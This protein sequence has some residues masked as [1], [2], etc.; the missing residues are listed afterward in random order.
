VN[1]MTE[2]EALTQTAERYRQEGYEVTDRPTT[3]DLPEPLR[4]Q[5]PALVARKNGKSTLIEVWSRDKVHDLPPES[6]PAGWDFDVV[7]I[8]GAER[9]LDPGPGPSTSL[10]FATDLLTELENAVP[11]AARQ[12]RFLLGWSTVEAAMRVAARR[13]LGFDLDP[14]PPREL[15]SE[16]YTFGVLSREQYQS[17]HRLLAV[18]NRLAHGFPVDPI[19]DEDI[20]ALARTARALLVP[21]TVPAV[22]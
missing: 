14:S 5:Y 13:D 4:R 21:E 9:E 8:P 17:L 15:V 6:L 19:G 20:Q 12:S 7:L 16:L 18:R 11:R 2:T 22:G 3:A 1:D 10:E